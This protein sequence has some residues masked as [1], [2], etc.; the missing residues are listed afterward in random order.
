MGTL[1]ERVRRASPLRVRSA[2]LQTFGASRPKPSQ[3]DR[4]ATR[5]KNKWS[6]RLAGVSEGWPEAIAML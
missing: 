4:V 1:R 2:T 5:S 3:E 6:S